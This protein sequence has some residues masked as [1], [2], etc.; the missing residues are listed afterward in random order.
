MVVSRVFAVTGQQLACQ[1]PASPISLDAML[2][3]SRMQKAAECANLCSSKRRYAEKFASIQQ[4]HFY[5]EPLMA[6]VWRYCLSLKA[7]PAEA[8]R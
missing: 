3:N 1:N 7:I 2:L 5:A 4:G 8:V 6:M